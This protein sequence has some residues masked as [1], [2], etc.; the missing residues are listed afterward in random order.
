MIIYFYINADLSSITPSVVGK[1]MQWT[2]HP[3]T[4]FDWTFPENVLGWT[5]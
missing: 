2:L 4:L 3:I 1:R 5:I